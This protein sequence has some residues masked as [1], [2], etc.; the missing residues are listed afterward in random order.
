MQARNNVHV[1]SGC[2]EKAPWSKSWTATQ[3]PWGDRGSANPLEAARSPL[4]F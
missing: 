1:R 2:W 3:G 4:P